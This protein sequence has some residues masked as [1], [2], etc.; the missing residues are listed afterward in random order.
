MTASR[1]VL[2]SI[3]RL[4]GSV[5]FGR[6]VRVLAAAVAPLLPAGRLVDVGCGNGEIARAVA[7]LRPD[8]E[9]QG[10]D[11]LIRPS[12]AIPARPF[13]GRTLPLPDGAA[14]AAL[15]VDVLHHAD[16]PAALL[17]ECAR[18]ARVVVVKDHLARSA[19]D[20]KVLAFMDWV[21]NRPHGVVLP[22]AY[23]SPEGW[24]SALGAAA[25]REE[26]RAGV[27]GLYPAPFSALF[28][29]GLH[30]VARLVRR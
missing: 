12:C 1:P 11:V 5:V 4:H 21:G 2:T 18:V 28:G 10:F 22:Y 13:D 23:F 8:V 14:S 29:R 7:A 26:L 20:R 15:L 27:P 24:E 16:D 6:R 17:S 25:L 3:G 30:F 19:L 9:P